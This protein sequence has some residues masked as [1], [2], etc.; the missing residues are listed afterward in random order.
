MLL[1]VNDGDYTVTVQSPYVATC[2]LQVTDGIGV[3]F[4]NYIYCKF[5]SFVTYNSLSTVKLLKAPG[6]KSESELEAKFLKD[7][8]KIQM[9]NS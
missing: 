3:L 6:G 2:T 1:A 9:V 5:K 7:I 8:R 4:Y